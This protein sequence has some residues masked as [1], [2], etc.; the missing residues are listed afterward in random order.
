MSI[1]DEKLV[2][3]LSDSDVQEHVRA[4]FVPLILSRTTTAEK[5]M[6]QAE[7]IS[8]CTWKPYQVTHSENRPALP[9]N[10]TP[11]NLVPCNRQ[12]E[13]AMK[14]FL[15]RAPDVQSFSKNAGPQCL[16][17]DYLSTAGR[18]SYYTPDFFVKKTDGHYVLIE[19]K[20]RVDLDVPLKASAAIAWC[21]GASTKKVK[22]DYLFVQQEIF[23]NITSNK[24]DDLVRTCNP[25]LERLVREKIEPQ[26]QLPIGEP[27]KGKEAIPEDVV[28]AKILEKLPSRYRKSVEQAFTMLKF[29]EQKE[30]MQ[31]GPVFQALLGPIDDASKGLI[32][33]LLKSHV[34]VNQSEQK[35]FFFPHYGNV[36]PKEVSQLES[37]A[38]NLRKT[39]VF[40]NGF[41]PMGTLSFC[42][43]YAKNYKYEIGGIF[44][45]IKTEFSKFND[46]DLYES[47]KAINDFRNTHV[48]HQDNKPLTD[49]KVAR[50]ALIN[51]IL[52][53]FK[54]YN[55]HN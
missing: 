51:W 27:E 54:I 43:D 14:E 32:V 23:S 49:K 5:R 34:P 13:V 29:L 16:R 39:L 53:L 2:N 21:K 7:P 19:T 10:R 50:D 12:F 38:K 35:N 55:T 36:N 20:G 48:A 4:T 52:G 40:N 26:L 37:K 33:D 6:L 17:I 41:F 46:T 45:A 3:R 24:I 1:Y 31:F 15:G 18:L 11:F 28:E 8:V 22:W 9:D 47:V 30:G 25:S 42:L 44:E